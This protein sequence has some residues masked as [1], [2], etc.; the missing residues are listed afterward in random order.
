MRQKPNATQVAV[1]TAIATMLL[2]HYVFPHGEAL[3]G[4]SGE[5]VVLTKTDAG[6]EMQDD[7]NVYTVKGVR[8]DAV[9]RQ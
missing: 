4:V 6:W 7:G 8:L 3:Q 5:Q 1:A 9:H 2:H